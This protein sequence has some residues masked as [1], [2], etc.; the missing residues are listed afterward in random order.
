MPPR[1]NRP[2]SGDTRRLQFID[3]D[4]FTPGLYSNSAIA[5]ST[6][7]NTVPGPFAAPTG[8]A[9]ASE[10]WQCIALPGGGLGPLPGLTNQYTLGNLGI[11][12][13]P[14]GQLG[15]IGG[16]LATGVSVE[17]EMLVIVEYQTGGNNI[18]YA[19]SGVVGTGVGHSLYNN[20]TVTPAAGGIGGSPYPFATRVAA[21]NPTTTIG[22]EVIAFLFADQGRIL[23][24]PDPAN[25][26]VFGVKDISGATNAA[27]LFGHQTRIVALMN[28]P[29]SWPAPTTVD[30]NNDAINY[31]DPP[32]SETWPGTTPDTVF[33]AEFPF[34]YGAV[35]SMNAGELF[36]VK[37]RGGGLIV[38][39]DINNPTVV[40]LPGV[41]PT[42]VKYG[43]AD[44]GAL[45]L[46]YCS[47]LE[48]A[49]IWTGGNSSQ[50]IS[51]Q[52]DDN[53][54]TPQNL[55]PSR[56]F[57]FFVKRWDNLVLFSNNF[58][59]DENTQGWWRLL[60]P[61]TASLFH[62]TE[63]FERGQMY[64][65]VT[66]VTGTTTDFLYQFDRTKPASSW[67]WQ[68]LPI[69]VSEDRVVNIREIVARYSNPYGGSGTF[70]MQMSAIDSGGNVISATS[71]TWNAAV[72]RPQM[73]RLNLGGYYSEDI[74][75]RIVME[76]NTAGQPAPVLHSLSVGYRTSEHAGAVV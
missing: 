1:P 48:G 76:A 25:P 8:A 49:W 63:G 40:W 3:I 68:S 34:G 38:S 45:G 66:Q 67:Q 60:N 46:Y 23:L 4:D 39:G 11:T 57:D 71:F 41:M 50:K 70:T 73:Q 35:G 64:G 19:F 24:Y 58:V 36:M 32:N 30:T 13:P 20:S 74:T 59:F 37:C 61:A 42:G 15:Y 75:I 51:S 69:R 17:D 53:F 7:P 6:P 44:S 29:Y 27:G 52:L 62:Y 56:F 14:A 54:Y 43:H 31:T 72:N 65:A 5:Y 47:E 55:I 26:T 12:Q 2:Q 22:A 16:L 9:D 10:T 28:V 21:S 33:V 18:F